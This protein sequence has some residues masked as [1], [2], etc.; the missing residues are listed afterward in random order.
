MGKRGREIITVYENSSEEENGMASEDAR[1]F[2]NDSYAGKEKN[3]LETERNKIICG[4]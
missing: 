4:A 3:F 1:F 2:D